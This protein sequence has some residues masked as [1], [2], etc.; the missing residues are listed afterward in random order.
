MGRPIRNPLAGSLLFVPEFDEGSDKRKPAV[1]EPPS[2]AGF[3]FHP[4]HDEHR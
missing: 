3:A 1:H 4:I 2:T